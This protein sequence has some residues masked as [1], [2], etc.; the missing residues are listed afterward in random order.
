MSELINRTYAHLII[1]C[2]AELES[3]V[4]IPVFTPSLVSAFLKMSKRSIESVYEGDASL[5]D[6]E[7]PAKK[8]TYD[9]LRKI[10]VVFNSRIL[11]FF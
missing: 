8:L 5:V 9:F 4:G 10:F 3:K 11:V 7:S 6:R 2:P 1:L